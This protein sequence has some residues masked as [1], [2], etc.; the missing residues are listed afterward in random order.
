MEQTEIK[1]NIEKILDESHTGTM[2]TIKGNKPHSRYMT[3]FHR[4][5]KLFTP[6]HKDADKTEEID[7]NPYT[8]IIIGY[9]GDGFGDAF[10]EYQGKVSFNQSE[11]MKKQLWNED[12]KI[13]FDG[14]DDPNY[15]I[16]E[17]EPVAIRLMNKKGEAPKDLKI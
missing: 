11:E 3:F 2:A 9:E 6:T 14:P 17:V 10:V 16:L 7:N 4:G 1:A 13:Y 8:H 15:L 12:M 5:L